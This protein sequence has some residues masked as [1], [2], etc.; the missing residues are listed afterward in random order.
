MTLLVSRGAMTNVA[1]QTDLEWIAGRRCEE[2][3]FHD[4]DYP[5]ERLT[6]AIAE[7]LDS[8]CKVCQG[9]E[10]RFPWLWERCVAYHTIGSHPDRPQVT[11]AEADCTG[12]VLLAGEGEQLLGLLRVAEAMQWGVQLVRRTNQG[13]WNCGLFADDGGRIL[14]ID[15]A[16]TLF[17]VLASACRK[18]LEV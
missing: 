1:A 10:S 12:H 9:T 2:Y 17:D 13:E 16:G 14:R 18:A 6:E 15:K 8:S 4:C 7:R 3:P 5:E 11:H